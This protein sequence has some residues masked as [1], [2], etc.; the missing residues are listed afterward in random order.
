MREWGRRSCFGR[1]VQLLHAITLVSLCASPELRAEEK[2][3]ALPVSQM[4]IAEGQGT[5]DEEA[6]EAAKVEAVVKVAKE[7][8]D[9]D[10]PDSYD[11][12]LRKHATASL[13]EYLGD[14]KSLRV[15]RGEE[16]PRARLVTRVRTADLA[17]KLTQRGLLIKK[18]SGSSG[19]SPE[20]A[21]VTALVRL[22]KE[23][24]RTFYNV[25]DLYPFGCIQA[26]VVEKPTVKERDDV[27][28]EMTATIR[29]TMDAKR[30]AELTD[31]LTTVL[32]GISTVQGEYK[33]NFGAHEREKD[34]FANRTKRKSG[35]WTNMSLFSWKDR[36]E[37]QISQLKG[38]LV[39]VC[40]QFDAKSG[41][42]TWK[43]YFVPGNN[44]L[45]GVDSIEA[46]IPG[47]V[48]LQLL[49]A[50]GQRI[51]DL[52]RI[53]HQREQQRPTFAQSQKTSSGHDLTFGPMF[54]DGALMRPTVTGTYTFLVRVNDLQHYDSARCQLKWFPP[55]SQQ[56][57]DRLIKE[58]SERR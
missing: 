39:T 29:Y 32:A 44:L 5:T 43:Y 42:S 25:F 26:E 24:V 56:D 38:S 10:K 27:T 58:E 23:A 49:D 13:A 4:V 41:T 40:T 28:A 18:S 48:E 20:F 21:R 15:H 7:L 22:R 37:M 54:L 16:S 51:C 33:L 50:T 35:Y 57:A 30:Y 14:S 45:L 17:T 36:E 1:R 52:N 47:R 34:T 2:G 55:W 31:Y 53:V 19:E 11:A 9:T 3:S 12:E 46:K 8:L 6:V